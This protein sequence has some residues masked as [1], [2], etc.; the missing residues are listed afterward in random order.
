MTN[1]LVA[2]KT[3]KVKIKLS[4]KYGYSSNTEGLI[5]PDQWNHI[6]LVLNGINEMFVINDCDSNPVQVYT[7]KDIA[8]AELEILNRDKVC[9]KLHTA[10]LDNRFE[11]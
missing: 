8:E 3:A 10:P 7:N 1:D 9:Y 11:L 4:T 6:V 2:E 5:N